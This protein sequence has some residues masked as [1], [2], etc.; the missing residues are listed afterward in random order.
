MAQKLS[1]LFI[2]LSALAG[3]GFS[4]GVGPQGILLQFSRLVGNLG[5]L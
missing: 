5:L 1:P 3:M 2:A 4:S